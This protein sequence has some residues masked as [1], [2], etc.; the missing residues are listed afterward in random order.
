LL[1]ESDG[2][3][4]GHITIFQSITPNDDVDHVLHIPVQMVQSFKC[5]QINFAD[6]VVSPP[7]V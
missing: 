5:I 7:R 4:V 6:E 2:G 3:K 1:S